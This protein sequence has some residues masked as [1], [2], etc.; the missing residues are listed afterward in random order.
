VVKQQ[1]RTGRGENDVLSYVLHKQKKL[2][3]QNVNRLNIKKLNLFI[4]LLAS[5]ISVV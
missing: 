2:F 3:Q 1:I 4:S 5:C